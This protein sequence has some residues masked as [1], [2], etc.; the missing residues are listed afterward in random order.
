METKICTVCKT[1]IDDMLVIHTT[2]GPVHP[3][4][5][6]QHIEDMPMS[7]STD[8]ILAETSLLL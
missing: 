3:G 8:E 6:Y 4:Q 5:C 7:E 2:H 1:P